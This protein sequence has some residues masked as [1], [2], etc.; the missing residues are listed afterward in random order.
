LSTVIEPGTEHATVSQP[1]HARQSVNRFV[2]GTAQYIADVPAEGC[3]EAA[4]VRSPVA[5]G[6]IV[7]VDLAPA[8]AP[9]GPAV[10]GLTG[11]D[12]VARSAPM[13]CTWHIASHATHEYWCLPH[14]RVLFAGDPVAAV[15]APTAHEA[16]YAASL[17]TMTIAELPHVTDAEAAARGEVLLRP[18]TGTN[19]LYEAAAHGASSTGD[20]YPVAAQTE[21][22]EV[23]IR[24]LEGF[25]GARMAR[26]RFRTARV[27]AVP[28]EPRGCLAQVNGGRLRLYTS[29]QIP[30]MVKRV[31]VEV[32]GLAESDVEVIAPD[33]GGGFGIKIAVAR[34]EIA[35]CL[36][37]LQ[38]G[39][40]VRWIE[41]TIEHLTNAPHGRDQLN[42]VA[43]AW[44]PAGKVLGMH[45][46]CLSDTGAYSVS[47]LSSA[48]E[49]AAMPVRLPSIY[50][51]GDYSY[52]TR[53]VATNK[54]P[55]GTYRGVAAPVGVFI[56]E[57]LLQDIAADTGLDLA[58]VQRRNFLPEDVPTRNAAGIPYDPGHYREAF[59]RMLDRLDYAGLLAE[60]DRRR[61]AGARKLIGIGMGAL[62]EP[63]AVSMDG[64]GLRVVT[65][66]ED[67]FVR[68]NPDGTAEVRISATSSGQA[69]ET[70]FAKIAGDALGIDRTRVQVRSNGADE[71]MYGSGSWGSRVTVVA[72]GAVRQAAGAVADKLCAIAAHRLGVS[73]ERT[74]LAENGVAGPDGQFVGLADLCSIAYFRMS[75]LPEGMPPGLAAFASYRPSKGFTSPYGFHGC[76]I[77][78]DTLTGE[79]DITKYVVVSDV[80]RVITPE[81]LAEQ[82]RGGVAQGLGEALFEQIS[83]DGGQQAT[84]SLFDYRLPRALDVPE[85][86]VL[87]L[88]T[89]A[90]GNVLGVRGAGEDGAIGAPAAIATAITDALMPVGFKVNALPV[91]FADL[92]AAGARWRA[93]VAARP[94][95]ATVPAGGEAR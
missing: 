46:D 43:V 57:R 34:E 83:Y 15:A 44:N 9:R 79:L 55:L 14:D 61:Q 25:P 89:P 42:D 22:A 60:Q 75:D 18:S 3:L 65:D 27:T 77:S 87:H 6:E 76:A 8:L 73:P 30:V 10:A 84:R 2:E 45:V 23:H 85:V 62:V 93:A 20:A 95:Q 26:N 11:R 72:G 33:V 29:T 56:M 32:L 51:L 19:V 24:R 66:W 80:G 31:L 40:P 74:R 78:L 47:P 86:E 17:V 50:D 38:T 81:L 54:P 36:L 64:L 48:I 12:A 37:A 13:P 94:A 53:A 67:A 41:D 5:H 7:A 71:S 63:S 28:M 69:H 1:R 70:T 82:V 88:E 58:E 49:A 91:N 68:L 4:F 59:S 16:Q 21:S 52:R 92:I 35:V 39:R 90:T